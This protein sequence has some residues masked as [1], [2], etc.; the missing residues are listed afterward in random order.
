[1]SPLTFSDQQLD[2]IT[3]ATGPLQPHERSAF[4]AA[5]AIWFRNRTEVGDGELYRT[6]A[7]LQR[8]HFAAPD[9]M[10]KPPQQLQRKVR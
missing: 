5:L 4:L 10:E 7:S 2:A 1:M 3:R 9:L 6:L 8:E